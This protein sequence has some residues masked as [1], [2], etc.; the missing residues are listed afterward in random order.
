MVKSFKVNFILV[1]FLCCFVFR[2]FGVVSI[3]RSVFIAPLK[4]DSTTN[5]L[6]FF[7]FTSAWAEFGKYLPEPY[8]DFNHFWIAKAGVSGEVLRYKN[9]FSV[10]LYSDIELIASSNNII[11]FDPRAFYWQEGI[12]ISYRYNDFNFQVSFT[13]RC[14]HDVDNADLVT[15]YQEVRARVIIW[16]SIMFRFFPDPIE[17]FE[18]M[19][20]KLNVLPFFRNDFYVLSVD[21]MVWYRVSFGP[22][23]VGIETLVNDSYY[24]VNKIIDSIS[25]GYIL[26]LSV[27]KSLGFYSKGY[28]WF[29]LLGDEPIWQWGGVK[30]V[31]K[32]HYLEFGFYVKGDGV[33]LM[34]F[35]QNNLLREP[36]IEPFD[37]GYVNL[38]HIGLKAVNE[39][40]MF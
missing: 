13:H 7:T 18:Y 5:D 15:L 36:A 21:D 9:V 1:L 40:F 29:D 17:L 10:L 3:D 25:F 37:Q 30:E 33:R 32:E 39:K 27:S 14:K 19:G 11:F 35:I 28:L 4:S 31:I 38:F 6:D 8:T 2:V 26:D 20:T 23:Y 24:R 34:L 16:D 22:V 12:L